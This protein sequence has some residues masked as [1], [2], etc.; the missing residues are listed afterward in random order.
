[1]A[2]ELWLRPWALLT[3]DNYRI[4]LSRHAQPG[5]EAARVAVPA[6]HDGPLYV[7]TK[8]PDLPLLDR[9]RGVVTEHGSFTGQD[10]RSFP[11]GLLPY[12]R[13][14]ARGWLLRSGDHAVQLH[15]PDAPAQPS[16]RGDEQDTQAPS[17][18]LYQRVEMIWARLRD[19]ENALMD[20]LA[21]WDKVADLWTSAESDARNPMMEPIA[22]QARA[23]PTTLDQLEH[24]ARRILRRRHAMIPVSR[25][26]EVD[27]RAML[28]LTRQPGETLAERAGPTQRIQAVTR[29]ESYNTLENR[30]LHSYAR[31]A[32]REALDYCAR[33]KR[34]S[35]AARYRAV[36]AFA[37]RCQR[38][39][40]RLCAEDRRVGEARPDVTPNF[41][42]QNNPHYNAV[43]NAWHA[44]L[45][46]NLTIDELWRW[47]ARA[48][49]EVCAVA[50]MVA[51]HTLP[52]AR[53]IAASPLTFLEEQDRGRWLSH[54]NPLGVFYLARQKRV[55]EVQ[56]RPTGISARQRDFAAPLW[57]RIGGLDNAR[58]FQQRVA[59]WPLAGPQ[60]G[61]VDGEADLL[62]PALDQAGKADLIRAGMIIRA[63]SRDDET[64]QRWVAGAGSARILAT[65]LA[66]IGPALRDGIDGIADFLADQ[67]ALKG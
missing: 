2:L 29:F 21:V 56:H 9:L 22:R 55:I 53:L 19:L 43:W 49:E 46:R 67:I 18:V 57:L 58:A 63:A 36:E 59:I 14:P 38:L 11:L 47:Q 66:P 4:D 45:R 28:W 1:M 3:G 5:E 33:Y 34:A 30:V 13:D 20:P 8:A 60:G 25:A 44:L 35:G 37:K 32:R 26:Q 41:V 40:R 6:D 65:T 48:F 31:L 64:V 10:G 12:A 27:R 50:V 42:L 39:H 16:T 61:L 15:W 7:Y 23:L 52:G 51:L 62:A 17:T 54:D 24:G